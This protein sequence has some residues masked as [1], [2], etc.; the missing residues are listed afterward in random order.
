VGPLAAGL[1][2]HR[3]EGGREGGVG[4][5]GRP[6][7]VVHE[8]REGGAPPG[9]RAAAGGGG[10]GLREAAGLHQVADALPRH[11]GVARHG[12][13]GGREVGEEALAGGGGLLVLGGRDPFVPAAPVGEAEAADALVARAAPPAPRPGAV[14]AADPLEA[15]LLL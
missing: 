14:V 7:V 3:G 2:R 10:A 8:A 6:R 9:R 12:A 13:L 1:L 4:G 5:A 15:R 11:P